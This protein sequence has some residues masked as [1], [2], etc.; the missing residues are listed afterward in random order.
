MVITENSDAMEKGMKALFDLK[1][2][3]FHPPSYQPRKLGYQFAPMHMIFD[4]KKEDYHH[5]ARVVIGGHT[6]DSSMYNTYA[7]VIQTM[8]I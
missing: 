2:F 5:K 3:E 8:M 4:T 6:M 1:C 7:T